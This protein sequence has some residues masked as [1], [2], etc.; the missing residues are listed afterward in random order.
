MG[1]RPEFSGFVAAR[2]SAL[3]RTAFLLTGDWPG[4]EDLLQVSLTKSWRSWSRV[5][6][7][8]D[9][10]VRAV[11]VNTYVSWRRRRWHRETPTA[12]LPEV[13]VGDRT[14]EVDEREA[15]W[16][17]LRRLPRRQRAVVV[18]RY[19]DDLTEAET[20]AML[21]I[22]VGTV[23]SQCSKAL[24]A[25]RVDPGLQPDLARGEVPTHVIHRAGPA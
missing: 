10:Y 13:L 11:M 25:L 12:D 7:R 18:L 5:S 9:A 16:L 17:A 24:T 20:A 6:D 4:A 3:L 2:S 8:P 21:G 19:F 22:S 15:L 23:K 1:D 14:T